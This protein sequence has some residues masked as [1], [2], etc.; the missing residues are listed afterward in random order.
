MEYAKGVSQWIHNMS[1]S[2][3]LVLLY[4][5]MLK[6]LY[7]TL[8]AKNNKQSEGQ[9]LKA[10]LGKSWRMSGILPKIFHTVKGS[11]PSGNF[12]TIVQIQFSKIVKSYACSL[13]QDIF[14]I[15][16]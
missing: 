14:L 13:C 4:C 7:L 9:Y 8:D 15:N 16:Q 2:I 5:K 1:M 11:A 6:D 3:C 12:T 10:S